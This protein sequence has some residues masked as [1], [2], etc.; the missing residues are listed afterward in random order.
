MEQEADEA[1]ERATVTSNTRNGSCFSKSNAKRSEAGKRFK[2]PEVAEE[3]TTSVGGSSSTKRPRS[4]KRS[5]SDDMFI[6]SLNMFSR[7]SL[8]GGLDSVNDGIVV[9][10]GVAIIWKETS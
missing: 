6:P 2:S 9:A 5:D 1:L 3:S 7:A 4:G 10:E 8:S